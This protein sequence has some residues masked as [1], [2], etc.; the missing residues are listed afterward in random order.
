L[1]AP[2][3]CDIVIAT[4]RIGPDRGYVNEGGVPW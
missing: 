4:G 2:Q 1:I 3:R